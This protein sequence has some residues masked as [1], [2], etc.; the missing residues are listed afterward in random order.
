[1]GA[2]WVN[3]VVSCLVLK[4]SLENY[5]KKAEENYSCVL[6]SPNLHAHQTKIFQEEKKVYNCINNPIFQLSTIRVKLICIYFFFKKNLKLS[7]YRIYLKAFFDKP[8]SIGAS[9]NDLLAFSKI[10]FKRSV[11]KMTF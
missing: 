8:G 4:K 6:R 10:D 7:S 2:I 3:N 5:L 1:M 11:K 9:S